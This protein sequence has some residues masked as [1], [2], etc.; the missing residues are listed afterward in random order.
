M[1]ALYRNLDREGL[2]PDAAL[3]AARK[4]LL[5]ES[6]TAAPHMWAPFVIMSR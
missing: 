4:K 1:E 2:P 5:Q 6:T 3:A